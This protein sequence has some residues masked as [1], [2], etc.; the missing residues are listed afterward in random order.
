MTDI[1]PELA[2][3]LRDLAEARVQQQIAAAAKAREVAA[4]LREA[5]DRRR[6]YGVI[7]RNAAR[8]ARIRLTLHHDT[9]E[10]EK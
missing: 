2:A 3:R 10:N 4:Q 5:Q 7:A 8:E 9:K 6:R 1:D